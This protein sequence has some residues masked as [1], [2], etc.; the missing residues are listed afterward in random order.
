M[1]EFLKEPLHLTWV[2][3]NKCNLR[4]KFCY[5]EDYIG[6]DLTFEQTNKILDI[7]KSKQF[8]HVSLLGGEPTE[9]KYF[10]YVISKLEE[11]K[12]S[13][14]FSTNA[15]KLSEDETLLGLLSNSKYLREVQISLESPVSGINDEVRGKK[16]YFRA[17]KGIQA[18]VTK[19]IP[20]TLAMVLTKKNKQTVQDMV[21]LSEDLGVK[22]LRLMPFV[23][24]GTGELAKKQLF[25]NYKELS[26]VCQGLNVPTKL[27]VST[28][29][30]DS[31]S[32]QKTFGC[33]AGTAVCVINND[34]TLSACPL[35]AQQRS[36]KKI[37]DV[38]SFSEIWENSK[39]FQEWRNGKYREKTSC[40]LCPIFSDCGGY[41]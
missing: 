22:E 18:S 12:I 13:Y 7:I 4:C 3:T 14:S 35:T 5:L 11:F 34:L 16:S 30:K 41:S 23:P 26:E 17:M 37:S 2:L 9:F 1:L 29:L 32:P 38:A 36:S 19:K 27:K 21:Y 8:L 15:Q 31:N 28:Y 25:M 39:I 24:I 20:V 10:N 40:N 6:K 33:G